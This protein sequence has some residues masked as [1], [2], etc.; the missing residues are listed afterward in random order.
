[1]YGLPQSG[2]ITQQLLKEC[3]GKVGY[4]QSKIIP[5]LWKHQ[6]RAMSF[7]LCCQQLCHKMHKERRPLPLVKCTQEGLLSDRRLDGQKMPRNHHRVGLQQPKS[8]SL[9]ARIH[10]E[11]IIMLQTRHT[12][13]DAKLTASTHNPRLRKQIQYAADEDDTSTLGKNDRKCIQQVAGAL[14]Y[15]ARAVNSTI[16]PALSSIATKQAAPIA[17]TMAKVKQ[18]VDYVSTQQEAIITYRASDMILSVYSDA[19]YCNE[20]KAQS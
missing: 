18:L 14:L 1:M 17:K 13:K 9:D 3:L 16:L 4:T 11:G 8:S 12:Q 7:L 2:I 6:T 20:K 5:G 19:G 15:Y 10:Q